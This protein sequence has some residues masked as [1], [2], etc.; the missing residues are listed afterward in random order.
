MAAVTEYPFF[1]TWSAQNAARPFELTGGEGAWFTT[2]DGSRWLDLGALSYQVNAG[3]GQRRIIEAIKRQADELC[4]S[5]PNAVYPAKVELAQRLL[6]MAGPGF[7]KVFFTLGGAEANENAIKIARQVTGRLK[8]VS[9]YRSYHGASMGALA[10]TGDWRRPALEPALAGV[11]HV[12]DCYCDRCP[13]GQRVETCRRECATNIGSTMTLEGPRSVAAV[14]LEPVPG[15]NGVLV[16]PPEYWPIVRQA[17]DA[18]GALLVADE[19]LTGFGRTGK[20]FGFQ[21]WDVVPDLITVAKGLAS[22]YASI[23]AVI[24]HERVAKHFDDHVLACGLTYYAHPL[25]CA[26]ALETLKLYEDDKLFENA[27]RLGPILRRELDV[28]A[29]RLPPT[30]F[31]R[32]LGLLA[33]LELEAPAAAWTKLGTELV[34]RK[35]SLHVDPKRGTAIFAPPLCI[36]EQE[37]VTGLR[38]FGEAAVVAFEGVA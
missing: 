32:S 9:R 17:C 13:F 16:P 29:A 4:L 37:L 1:F 25:A 27:E 28:V 36:T 26:A 31:V 14:F 33:A 10:L 2:A 7:S 35:L 19:V 30:T 23:G 34:A 20:P 21:H 5:A 11:I 38:S 12:Q 8:L 6:A 15:A 22:G 18:E 3:H 24:V